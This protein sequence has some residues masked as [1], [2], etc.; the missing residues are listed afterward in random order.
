[1]NDLLVGLGCAL[2]AGLAGWFVPAVVRTLPEPPPPPDEEAGA[3]GDAGTDEDPPRTPRKPL[4]DF[5]LWGLSAVEGDKELYRDLADVRRLGLGCA[6]ASALVAGL[7]GWHFGWYPVL[8]LVVPPVPVFVAIA[9]VD[10]RTRYIPN[11]LVLPVTAYVVLAGVVL[12]LALDAR[13]ELV[14]GLVALVVVRTFFWVFWFVRA[15]GMGF[16]DVRLSAALGFV[17]GFLGP[18]EAFFG[19]W[20]GFIVF[21][22]PGVLLALAKRDYQLMRVPFPFGPFMLVGALLG[23]FLGQPAVDLLYG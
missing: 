16:G 6:I 21:T 11:R 10:W 14:R 18:G 5:T 2:L 23:V 22:L 4:P 15:A 1:M 9:V 8:A 19:V 20:L 13:T 3:E 17:L 12:W 7:L